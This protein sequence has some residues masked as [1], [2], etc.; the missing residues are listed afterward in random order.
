MTQRKPLDGIRVLDL[1]RIISGPYC[2]RLLADCGAE[3]I[4]I[5][6]LGGEHM[7]QKQPIQG[8]EST[9]FGHLNAGKKSVAIDFR[10][11]ADLARIRTLAKSCDIAVENF[12]P[13]VVADL[14]LDYPS[15]SA[16]R[17]DMIYCSISGFGQQGPRATSPA[18]APILHALS[19]HDLASQAYDGADAPAKTGIW[20]AD[21][22]G[23]AYA[24]AAIQTALVGRLRHGVGCYVDVSLL[25]TMINLMVLEVQE[26]QTPSAFSRWLATP[27]RAAD[28]HVMAIPITGR[29]FERLAEAIG[30][31]ELRDDPR[32]SAQMARE[33]N[34]QALMVEIERWTKG[35]PASDVEATLMAAGVPCARYQTVAEAIDDPQVKARGLMSAV[36]S[37]AGA[38]RV[39][40]APF[41][42]GGAP[43]SVGPSVPG[44]GS[45]TEDYLGAALSQTLLTASVGS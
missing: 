38:F 20:Y 33:E 24:F 7:R 40:G 41:H 37:G 6:P 39:P 4:K 17:P 34:W 44:V 43:L 22:M 36:E 21:I 28:G 29:N 12:R 45:H 32:F 1:T 16:E 19:G 10:D 18:Y 25:D 42:F 11:P 8:N 14:G 27:V 13:G 2:T 9:Y 23:G 15:L 5:E 35:R 31:P 26:A 3:V 30:W